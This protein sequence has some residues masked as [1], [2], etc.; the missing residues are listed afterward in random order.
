[1]KSSIRS[2]FSSFFDYMVRHKTAANLILAFMLLG[3]IA[4][5]LKIR[6]QYFPDII[7][8]RVTVTVEW[9]G[10]GPEDMDRAVVELLGPQLLAIEGVEEASSVAREGRATMTLEFETGW[11]MGQAVDDAKAAVDQARS[12]LPEDVEEPTV[13]RSAFRD[14]VT[15]VVIYGP[16]NADQL[17]RYAEDLQTA[18]FREGVTRVSI[19]GVS[20]PVIRIN[21]SEAML[22]R[23]DLSLEEIADVVA[24]EMETTPAGDVA[25]GS[26]RL[27]TG[28]TRRS[29]KELGEIVLRSPADGEKLQLRSVAE[30]VTEGPESG[31]AYSHK[32]LPAVV[33]RVDRDAIGDTIK[34]QRQVEQIVADFQDGL[35][36]GVV[37]QLTE[38][39]A[40]N[41][42]DRLNILVENGLFGLVLVVGFL[43]LFLSSRTAFWVAAGIPAAMAAT[44]A[45]MFA[46]GVTLNMFSVFALI[47]CLGIVVDDAIVVGE[48]ADFLAR[49]GHSPA[50]AAVLAA[51]RMAAPVFSASITTIIAF[52]GL[53]AIGGRFGELIADIPL[54][55]GIVLIASLVESFLI[56]PA[57]MRH[58]LSA[59]GKDHWYD[60]PN[61]TFNKGFNA[62]RRKVFEPLMRAVIVFRYPVMG[63]AVMTL[64]IASSM[65]F[66]GTVR[67]RFFNAP[68]RNVIN[69]NIA[70]MPGADRDDTKAMLAEMDRALDVVDQRYAEEYGRAPVS[71]ALATVGANA[72][73]RALNGADT[74]DEDLLGGLAIELIDPDL[75]PY[76]AFSFIGDW[77][78][79]IRKGPLLETL[80]VR[81][82][83]SG[84]GGDAIDVRL[85]GPSTEILKEAAEYL[86]QALGAMPGVSA[87]EDTLSFDKAEL[88]LNLTPKGEALGF[89][90][91]SVANV[92]RDRLEGIKVAEFPVGRRTATVRVSLPDEETGA[93][94]VYETQL[95]SPA[96]PYVALSEIVEVESTFGFASVRRE[97]GLQTL[98]VS[99]DISEDDPEAAVAVM[100]M[101]SETLLPEL[102]ARYDVQSELSGLAEQEKE[103]LSDAVLALGF[104]LSG[105]YLTLCWIF[106]SWTRPLVIMLVIP[107]GCIGMIWGHYWHHL[108]LSMFSLIGFIGMAGI[109]I[110][111]SIVLVTTIDEYAR[112]RP[113]RQALIEGVSDRLRPVVLTSAT[114]VFG[115]APLLFETSRQAQFLMP[116]VITLAYG[117]GFGLFVVILVTPAMLAIQSD[118]GRFLKSGHRLARHGAKPRKALGGA[119][120]R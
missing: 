18:L 69:A 19:D 29:E 119:R 109:I 95:K 7:N 10:A 72:G 53:L 30:I 86:K 25:S 62:F 27:R 24:T 43:F 17:S 56:L 15:N 36:R 66:D 11:D 77:R 16:I 59:S 103:F 113:F 14:R 60:W 70:M 78:K 101:L 47:I 9:S 68:E 38:T 93:A 84:P 85:Y 74:K 8:E 50:E 81:G 5:G 115:L 98:R 35:P 22:I 73:R 32:G 52:A 49:K 40:Q 82:E 111:D 96:G 88:A 114:T 79:E 83:R 75:R 37:A 39:R 1:M 65:Y 91:D 92:L 46:F 48:H 33:L 13:V 45:M 28:Q 108:P 71:F 118:F 2:E 34:I 58:A 55:V 110:N 61:R 89:T 67:W 57:H 64:L 116:T 100:A 105:I 120:A 97:N 106:A 20:N 76:S 99:G 21:T 31:K 112:D 80:A 87:L 63:L 3:G 44:I 23:H 42:V 102:A 4:A 94:F 26:A 41:I 51:K 90:T 117:L 54:T 104:C 6:T 107:F 12:S